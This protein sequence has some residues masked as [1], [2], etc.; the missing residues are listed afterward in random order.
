MEPEKG[1]NSNEERKVDKTSLIPTG[2]SS[3]FTRGYWNSHILIPTGWIRL[4]LLMLIP[5]GWII[6]CLLGPRFFASSVF[7]Q[8]ITQEPPW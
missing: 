6:K 1:E 7:L 5:T 2:W 4:E 3:K 8:G